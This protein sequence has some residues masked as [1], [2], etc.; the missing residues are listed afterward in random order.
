MNR[1]PNDNLTFSEGMRGFENLEYSAT[2]MM[3][4]TL[5]TQSYPP[6]NL[7]GFHFG[8]YLFTSMGMLG[9]VSSGFNK[10][11]LY[12]LLGLGVLIKNNYLTFNTFQI[13]VTFYPFV[14]GNGYNIFKTNAYKTSDYSFRNFEVS[15]PGIIDYR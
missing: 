12:S 2:R 14:P 4:L 1:L 13:S 15:K 7:L 5:Q 8:P 11:R 3:V 9:D 10:S 6:W